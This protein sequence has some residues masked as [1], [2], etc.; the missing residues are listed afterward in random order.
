MKGSHA[1]SIANRVGTGNRIDTQQN[2]EN[3]TMKKEIVRF[4]II[5]YDSTERYEAF[6]TYDS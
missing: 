5:V 6:I 4:V 2:K 3:A 1:T